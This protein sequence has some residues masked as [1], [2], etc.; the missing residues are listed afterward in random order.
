[1]NVSSG[2]YD[3]ELYLLDFDAAGRSEQITFSNAATGAVLNTQT[4]SSFA[5]GAY[6]NYMVSG[7]VLISI[8]KLSGPNGVLSG[9]FFD[10]VQAAPTVTGE[11]P[12][13]AATNV[14]VSSAFPQRSAKRFSP[15]P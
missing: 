14:P 2:S 6:M 13:S 9:M 11:S 12:A 5:T 1:M 3:L 10:P 8:K 7:N 15:A 4:V